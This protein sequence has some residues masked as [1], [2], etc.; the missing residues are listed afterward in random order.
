MHKRRASRP[1]FETVLN[2]PWIEWFSSDA[3]PEDRVQRRRFR[4]R[5]A[6]SLF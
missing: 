4:E 5:K 1:T 6:L 3:V 2:V